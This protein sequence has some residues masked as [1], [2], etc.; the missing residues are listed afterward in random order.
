MVICLSGFD[1]EK[2]PDELKE[3]IDLFTKGKFKN[4]LAI[5]E[6]LLSSDTFS[7]KDMRL[8][9]GL[10]EVI[11]GTRLLNNLKMEE[12]YSQLRSGYIK[13]RSF[14][15]RYKDIYLAKF[16]DILVKIDTC[17]LGYCFT[18]CSNSS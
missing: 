14:Y 8:F 1:S 13:L 5:I 2:L 16:L 12:G 11:E 17:V 9:E 7:S 4:S 3:A 15:P 10:Y 18:Y 6:T